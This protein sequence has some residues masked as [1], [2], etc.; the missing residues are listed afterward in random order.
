MF[1]RNIF[2]TRLKELRKQNKL[3]QNDLAKVLDVDRSFIAKCERGDNYPSV[4]RLIMLCNYL[5]V[6]PDYLLG[7]AE[8]FTTIY[9]KSVLNKDGDVLRVSTKKRPGVLIIQSEIRCG[10]EVK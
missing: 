2:S 5:K 1:R 10:G 4:D 8:K 7:Y 9:E 3:S 6:T